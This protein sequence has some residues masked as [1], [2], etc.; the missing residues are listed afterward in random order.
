MIP[1]SKKDAGG[2]EVLVDADQLRL[3]RAIVFAFAQ[4]TYF[5]SGH[6]EEIIELG[7]ACVS[8]GLSAQPKRT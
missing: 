1:I 7:L 4:Y 5:I 6:A 3:W 8:F 2:N